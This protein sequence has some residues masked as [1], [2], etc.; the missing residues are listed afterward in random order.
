MGSV[1][2]LSLISGP[3]EVIV[4]YWAMLPGFVP[5]VFWVELLVQRRLYPIFIKSWV[6]ENGARWCGVGFPDIHEFSGG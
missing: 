5:V 6:S 4:L 1:R 3:D 2:S